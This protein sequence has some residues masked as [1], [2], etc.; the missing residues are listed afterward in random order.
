MPSEVVASARGV[1]TKSGAGSARTLQ[2][3]FGGCQGVRGPRS[4]PLRRKEQGVRLFS[5]VPGAQLFGGR[6]G[7]G[8]PIGSGREAGRARSANLCPVW[9]E[10]VVGRSPGG[11]RDVNESKPW[12]PRRLANL[13]FPEVEPCLSSLL[14]AMTG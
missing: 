7:A 11:D 5:E 1:A 2:Q 14:A 9:M 3:A 12:T 6:G 4:A 13:T 10:G 8:T